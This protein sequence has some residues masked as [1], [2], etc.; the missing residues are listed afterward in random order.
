MSYGTAKTK[1]P[2]KSRY[3]FKLRSKSGKVG[4]SYFW[5]WNIYRLTGV[6]ATHHETSQRTKKERGEEP[7][8]SESAELFRDCIR[9]RLL[10]LVS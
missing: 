3:F 8:H 7:S 1:D 4:D 6:L 10:P 9:A 5:N 2:E